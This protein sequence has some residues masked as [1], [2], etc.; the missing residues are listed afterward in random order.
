MP[1]FA[2]M[3]SYCRWFGAAGVLVV[4]ACSSAALAC[5]FRMGDTVVG[6]WQSRLDCTVKEH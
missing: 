2:L 5:G 3:P 4:L 6:H 1:A